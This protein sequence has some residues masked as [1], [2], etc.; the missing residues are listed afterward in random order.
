[1]EHEVTS[2]EERTLIE[3]FLYREAMLADESRYDEWEALLEPD[4]TYWVPRGFGEFDPNRHISIINDNRARL[5]S[6]LRQLKTGT[7]HSQSPASPMR[8]MLA[9][10]VAVATSDAEY[11][12][13]SNFSLFEMQVQSRNALNIW[14]G[15]VLHRLRRTP[16]GLRMFHKKVMLVQGAQAVPTLAFLI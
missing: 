3:L 6:R 14:A 5:A 7:R 1:M 13:Q 9:N 10:I 16:E 11:R 15:S 8:R 12:V 4:M 2:Y